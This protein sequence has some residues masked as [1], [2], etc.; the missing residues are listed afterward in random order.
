MNTSIAYGSTFILGALHALEP[1][2]GKSFIAAYLIGE[3]LS[4]RNI[5]MLGISLLVS[6]FLLLVIIALLL[7]YIFSSEITEHL[8]EALS[9][10]G[11]V[12]IL[13]FGMYLLLHHRHSHEERG[14]FH[15]SRDKIVPDNSLKRSA[16][17]GVISGL[18]PCPTV[19][20]P[21]LMSGA[22]N[23]FHNAIFYILTY[24]LGMGVVMIGVLI[25]FVM[26]KEAVVKKFELISAKANPH[27]VSAVLVI[28]VG[29]AYLAVR[30]ISPEVHSD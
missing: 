24:V 23:N 7:R 4:L 20:A 6:H 12:I 13:V 29:L 16:I 8:H 22:V 5:L 26:L 27:L 17:V 3:K 1:G 2:H 9:W 21:I 15:A 14:L 28:I 10:A 25:L 30:I 18:L 19:V 11:P